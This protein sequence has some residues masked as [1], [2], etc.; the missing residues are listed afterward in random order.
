MPKI[1]V[2][3]LFPCRPDTQ[4]TPFVE[5]HLCKQEYIKKAVLILA[6]DVKF[7]RYPGISSPKASLSTLQ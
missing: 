5:F 4:T 3:G 1:A 2:F 7:G 6:L